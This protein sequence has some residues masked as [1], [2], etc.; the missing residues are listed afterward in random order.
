MKPGKTCVVVKIRLDA[1]GN[2]PV[3]ILIQPLCEIRK[4]LPLRPVEFPLPVIY[5]TASRRPV[6]CVDDPVCQLPEMTTSVDSRLGEGRADEAA[7]FVK[8][9]RGCRWGAFEL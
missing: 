8:G 4:L 1:V 6:A 2:H 7:A 3:P 5:P 9:V